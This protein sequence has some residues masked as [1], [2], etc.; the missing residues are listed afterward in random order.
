MSYFYSYTLSHPGLGRSRVIKAASRSELQEKVNTQ[1]RIWN[2]LYKKQCEANVRRQTK[3][4][5]ATHLEDAQREAESRTTEAQKTLEEIRATLSSGLKSKLRF[6]WDSQQ[7][8]LPF[9]PAQPTV[10]YHL[11]PTQP[12][13][14][15]PEYVPYFGL[16]DKVVGP[17]H[18]KRIA[19]AQQ[20]Y[21]AALAAWQDTCARIGKE[22]DTLEADYLAR[23]ENWKNEK[24][25]FESRQTAAIAAANSKAEK[26]AAGNAIEVIEYTTKILEQSSYPEFFEKS[27]DLDYNGANRVLTVNYDFPAIAEFP[28]L[29]SVRY[30]KS[31]DT[32]SETNL[33]EK[34][35]AD[36]YGSFLYQV[37]LRTIHEL[38]DTDSV[39]VLRGLAFNGYVS[40]TNPATG[41]VDRNCVLALNTTPQAFSPLN[42]A[43]V[44]PSEC[45]KSLGGRSSDPLTKCRAVSPANSETGPATVSPTWID[46]VK[47]LI[48][49]GRGTAVLSVQDLQ[50]KV[51]MVAS[52]R[53][54]LAD[55]RSLVDLMAN[56]GVAI[57][58]DASLLA[59]AYRATDAV[60]I[61]VPGNAAALRASPSYQGAAGV[62][63]MCGLVAVADGRL[64]PDEV[65]RTWDCVA[66]AFKLSPADKKR[67]EA[68]LRALQQDG[69]CL[70]RALPKVIAQLKPELKEWAAEV[71]V[72]VAVRN[73][74]LDSPERGVLDRIFPA[75]GIAPATQNQII[76]KYAAAAPEVTVLKADP[77]DIGEKITAPAGLKLDMARVAAI[78]QETKEV[79]AKLSTIM[80]DRES[81]AEAPTSVSPEATTAQPATP[82]VSSLNPSYAGI[83]RELISKP[84]WT[85]AE[86][87][88]LAGKYKLMP[89]AVTDVINAW[90]EDALGDFLIEG[91][92]PA[93]IHTE[94]LPACP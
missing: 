61:Y 24:H 5:R 49:T 70:W 9:P 68:L 12:D 8:H 52:S 29:E 20:K 75:V 78:S 60:A 88:E 19:E 39:K 22:N 69:G 27:F 66:E 53:A 71:A 74:V 45:F 10:A 58:P 72:Y 54:N 64:E 76:A 26:Y 30:V 65:S 36:L 32:F 38:I 14:N 7:N 48:G 83:Y 33:S 44:D 37:C 62:L 90:A 79:V 77:Q 63:A 59:Q 56:A 11:F 81:K 40:A 42:L 16:L 6:L 18:E 47:S 50:Q 41:N 28:K 94:L 23:V 92:D 82:S 87:V 17:L 21:Q 43:R 15:S 13:Q 2:D 89:V 3:A 84:R 55:S 86:F 31:Q 80:E 46:N 91:N 35:A 25:T 34:A 73:G 67:F 51:G 57:E 93:I 4:N 85:K 1:A